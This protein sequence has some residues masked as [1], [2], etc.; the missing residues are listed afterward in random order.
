MSKPTVHPVDTV[1]LGLMLK[2]LF[3]FNFFSLLTYFT[4]HHALLLS[5][6]YHSVPVS[7]VLFKLPAPAVIIIFITE[8]HFQDPCEQESK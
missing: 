8:G 4:F 2:Q 7:F 1:F 3:S 5:P 6:Y